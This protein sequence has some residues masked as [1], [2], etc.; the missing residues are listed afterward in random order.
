MIESCD[1][2]DLGA[3][4]LLHNLVRYSTDGENVMIDRILNDLKESDKLG[5]IVDIDK[6]LNK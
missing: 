5:V 1:Y 6:F 2:S 4:K 3:E